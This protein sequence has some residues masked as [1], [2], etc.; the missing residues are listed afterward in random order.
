M[1]RSG[2]TAA[3]AIIHAVT[4]IMSRLATTAAMAINHAMKP[5]KFGPTTYFT[6]RSATTAAS[7]TMPAYTST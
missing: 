6:I 5:R 7:M 3:M 1:L 2:T 4:P